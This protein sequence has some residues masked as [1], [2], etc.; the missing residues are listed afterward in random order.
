MTPEA[1]AALAGVLAEMDA[2][3]PESPQRHERGFDADFRFHELVCRIAALPR[4]HRELSALWRQTRLLLQQLDAHGIDPLNDQRLGPSTDHR[5]ILAALSSGEPALA[6]S[7]VR[8][9]VE[10]RRDALLEAVE[11]RG[12][13]S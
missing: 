2:A 4:L 12:G 1:L 9:H 3:E 6:A 8:R 13:L 7:T 5:A 10:N 11:Q